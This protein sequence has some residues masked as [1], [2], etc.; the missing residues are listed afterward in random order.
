MTRVTESSLVRFFHYESP[1]FV[2]KLVSQKFEPH[3]VGDKLTE[4]FEPVPEEDGFGE[5]LKQNTLSG[6]GGDYYTNAYMLQGQNGVLC[7]IK[8]R[9]HYIQQ[10]GGLFMPK[11]EIYQRLVN[12]RSQP[13]DRE[14]PEELTSALSEFGYERQE[15]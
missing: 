5:W 2:R 4:K 13:N 9:I 14:L 1:T 3:D 7:D 6:I 8:M 10:G 15:A 12:I 11:D